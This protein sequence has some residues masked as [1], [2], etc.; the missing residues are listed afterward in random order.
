MSASSASRSSSPSRPAERPPTMTHDSLR[1]EID[2][3]E[4]PELYDDLLTL[5][6]ELDDELTGMFRMTLALLPRADGSW[7]YLD[8]DRFTLWRRVVV[9]AGL[10]DD[11]PQLLSGYI[12][13]LR[14][15]FGLRADQC[16]LEIWGMDAGVLMDRADR[17]R[18]WP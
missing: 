14:P 3:S 10:V 5:E 15:E 6:V 9:T 18:D 7:A 4:V 13:H 8:D 16:V 1:I 11:T 12:T 2:G 17:L